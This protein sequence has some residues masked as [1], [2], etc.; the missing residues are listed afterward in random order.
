[1]KLTNVLV[2]DD[3]P[4]FCE[5]IK[6]L[7]ELNFDEKR[8]SKYFV[9]IAHNSKEAYQ[10]VFEEKKL[11]YDLV[12]LDIR[13]PSYP[14]KKIY[15][16]EDLADLMRKEKVKSKIVIITNIS[17]KDR[18]FSVY[19]NVEPEGIIIKTDLDIQI[20][21]EIVKNIL[22][23]QQYY[24]ESF[25]EL[26]KDSTSSNIFLDKFDKEILVQLSEGIEVKQLCD[27]FK[28]SRFE[29]EVRMSKLRTFFNIK[30]VTKLELI[31]AAKKKLFI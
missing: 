3:N 16:G 31:I 4:F 17:I 7:L 26:I 6:G 2:V 5:V 8:S 29:I 21:N 30:G 20:L 15:S 10:K 22:S 23:N 25:C 11:I 28:V 27:K 18:L 19:R 12:F 9:D 1:M 24:S 14:D 13:I